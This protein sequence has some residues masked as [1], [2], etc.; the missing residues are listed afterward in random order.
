MIN[1][2][3]PCDGKN[4]NGNTCQSEG[5]DLG[6]ISCTGMCSLDVSACTYECGDDGI[7]PGETCDGSDLDGM[8]CLSLG[9]DGGRGVIEVDVGHLGVLRGLEALHHRLFL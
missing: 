5:F 1:G 9:F 6:E 2:E 3:E 4:L 7:D 8:T